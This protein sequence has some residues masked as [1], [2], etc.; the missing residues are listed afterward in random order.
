MYC[1]IIN[2]NANINTEND[3]KEYRMWTYVPYSEKLSREKTFTNFAVLWLFVRNL[4]TR[5]PLVQQNQTIHKSFLRENR[6]FYQFTKVFSF[7]SFPLYSI[8]R[9][10]ATVCYIWISTHVS[11]TTTL[12][13]NT[14]TSTN[15]TKHTNRHSISNVCQIIPNNF[16]VYN[17]HWNRTVCTLACTL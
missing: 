10:K 6:I 17:S 1:T 5:C 16:R 15:H 14:T 12:R 9:I 7:E 13:T 8:C 4:G 3:M 2:S 11:E